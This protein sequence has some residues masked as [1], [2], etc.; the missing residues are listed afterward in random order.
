VYDSKTASQVKCGS[1]CFTKYID[2]T[3][4]NADTSEQST[5]RSRAL[6]FFVQFRFNIT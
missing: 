1:V 2:S 3:E 6:F 4:H 5:G